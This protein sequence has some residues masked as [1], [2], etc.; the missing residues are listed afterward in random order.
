M[1]AIA[2]DV[3][4]GRMLG[5]QAVRMMSRAPLK[6]PVDPRPLIVLPNMKTPLDRARAH[7][8]LPTWKI[9]METRYTCLF[10]N[11][12]YAFPASGMNT[13]L[14]RSALEVSWI[15]LGDVHHETV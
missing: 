2:V 4:T 9:T 3:T 5:G 11:T 8:K 6:R 12:V 1:S 13:Q 7:I 15:F 10:G 14:G